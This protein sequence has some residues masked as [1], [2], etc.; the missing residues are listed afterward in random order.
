[1]VS[2]VLALA[3]LST[4]CQADLN[5]PEQGAVFVYDAP[6]LHIHE[7]LTLVAPDGRVDYRL[8]IAP[9]PDAAARDSLTDYATLAGIVPIGD[10]QGDGFRTLDLPPGAF[11]EIAALPENDQVTFD[12]RLTARLDGET[13]QARD[14][15]IVRLEGCGVVETPAG[16]FDVQR[17]RVTFPTV[18]RSGSRFERGEA[19]RIVDYSPTLGWPVYHDYGDA[20]AAELVRVK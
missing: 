20:G 1:M 13:L 10:R 6:G 5:P 7:S 16:R 14:R 8:G 9:G 12:V 17:F 11:D 3:A 18:T 2:I 4:T 19:E 15:V